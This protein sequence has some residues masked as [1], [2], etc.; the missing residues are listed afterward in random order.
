V[1]ALLQKKSSLALGNI[2][3]S[4]ISNILGAFSLGLLVYP[5]GLAFDRSAKIYTTLLFVVSSAFTVVAGTRSLGRVVGV[6]CIAVFAVYLVSIGYVIY[7]GFLSAPEDSDSDSDSNSDSEDD[8]P[9]TEETTAVPNNESTEE[10]AL[11]PRSNRSS[12]WIHNFSYHLIYLILG[13]IAL[14]ISGFVL[15][16]SAASIA[17]AS[18]ISDTVIGVTILS[19]ATTLPEKFV[20]VMSG[21][22]GHGGIVVASTA[23]S[24]IFLLT[25]CLGV[26]LVAGDSYWLC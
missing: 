16:R 7:K 13:F 14:S 15:S 6:I 17:T 21:S 10:S 23:G 26:A 24:N 1:A 18:G 2:I 12:D 5:D 3:G 11:L 4:S 20:A 19:F 9:N 22:R 25:L 8:A